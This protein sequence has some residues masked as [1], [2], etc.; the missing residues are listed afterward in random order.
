MC[1]VRIDSAP[2]ERI[3]LILFLKEAEY[4]KW[5]QAPIFEFRKLP[6]VRKLSVFMIFLQYIEEIEPLNP[7]FCMFFEFENGPAHLF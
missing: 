7:H 1:D 2:G 4:S 5:A 3:F 6:K